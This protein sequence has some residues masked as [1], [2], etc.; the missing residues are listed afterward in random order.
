MGSPDG[1]GPEGGGG[2]GASVEEGSF[3]FSLTGFATPPSGTIYYSKIGNMVTLFLSGGSSVT[4]TSN[5]TTMTI[6]NGTL[7]EEIRPPLGDVIVEAPVVNDGGNVMGFAR[8]NAAG[9]ITFTRPTNPAIASGGGFTGSGT[10]GLARIEGGIGF[11]T[12]Y[13]LTYNP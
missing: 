10:K 1:S 3:P 13:G 9:G 11:Y 4:G 6:A 2:G 7:P 12:T 5:A 8:I